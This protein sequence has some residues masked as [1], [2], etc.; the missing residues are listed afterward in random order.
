MAAGAL[1]AAFVAAGL[2]L[3]LLRP[4]RWGE[5]LDGLT[6]A[7]ESLMAVQMPYAGADPWPALTLQLVGAV[8]CVVAGLLTFWPRAG[9]PGYPFFAIAALLVLAVT[10]LISL[11]GKRST[12]RPGSA[13]RA[14]RP[15]T[16]PAL[17]RRPAWTRTFDVSVRLLRSI[18]VVRPGA[19]LESPA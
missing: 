5:L 1:V 17:T 16:P 7:T 2:D 14:P 18:E 15:G 9:R 6:G 4:R 11:G 13:G 19:I 3:G 8:L 12:A 10:P